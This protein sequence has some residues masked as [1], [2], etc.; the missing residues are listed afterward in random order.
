MQKLHA[1]NTVKRSFIE[2]TYIKKSPVFKPDKEK[3]ENQK[4]IPIRLMQKRW[5]VKSSKK[6]ETMSEGVQLSQIHKCAPT[7]LVILAAYL[8]AVTQNQINCSAA[9]FYWVNVFPTDLSGWSFI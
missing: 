1:M 4:A 3:K 5:V 9:V 2:K 6:K 8:L 7:P